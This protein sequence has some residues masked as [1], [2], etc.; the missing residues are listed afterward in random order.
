MILNARNVLQ[1][2]ETSAKPEENPGPEESQS[3]WPLDNFFLDKCPPN[4]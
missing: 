4:N 3:R 2:F 1:Q